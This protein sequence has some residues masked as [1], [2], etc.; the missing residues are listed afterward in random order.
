MGVDI[1]TFNPES[2]EDRQRMVEHPGLIAYLT[3]EMFQA[4]QGIQVK[5]ERAKR[6]IVLADELT[7]ERGELTPTMKVVRR[8]VLEHFQWA[9][10]ALYEDQPGLVRKNVGVVPT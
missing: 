2:E 1:S 4:N 8:K 3:E 10:Q 6:F 5:Y 7:L 9:V